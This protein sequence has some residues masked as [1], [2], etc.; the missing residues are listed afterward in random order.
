[1]RQESNETCQGRESALEQ[2]KHKLMG[3]RAE[4]QRLEESSKE[5]A[6]CEETDRA[7]FA[8]L[9]RRDA[10]MAQRRAEEPGKQRQRRLGKIEGALRR[11]EAGEYGNCFMCNEEIDSLRLLADP[12]NTRCVKCVEG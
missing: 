8:G 10:L 4:L 3:L 2:L 11:I 12:T 1:M 6:K 5:T 7:A 9:S